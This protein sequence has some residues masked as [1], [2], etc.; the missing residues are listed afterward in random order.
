MQC[1]YPLTKHV[2]HVTGPPPS[3]GV[4]THTCLRQPITAVTTK[5]GQSHGT[6]LLPHHPRVITQAHKVST[7]LNPKI[8]QPP[9]QA[10]RYPR[11]HPKPH[12]SSPKH[13]IRPVV[14]QAPGALQ[15]RAPHTNTP[16][17]LQPGHRLRRPGWAMSRPPC[18]V[19]QGTRRRWPA[20][21]RARAVPS[22]SSSSRTPAPVSPRGRLRPPIIPLLV[23]RLPGVLLLPWAASECAAGAQAPLL[24]WAAVRD[25]CL[26]LH[27]VNNLRVVCSST[28]NT[29]HHPVTQPELIDAPIA[30]W[31]HP[32]HSPGAS[33]HVPRNH[34]VGTQPQEL[35]STPCAAG[36]I[37]ADPTCRSSDGCP[38]RARCCRCCGPYRN[39]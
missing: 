21:G 31:A 34:I 14:P 24:P 4:P 6:P 1:I 2:P 36:R 25:R 29:G 27:E 16:S 17:M 28:R 33:L 39:P 5:W 26:T 38:C 35:R 3:E 37:A 7:S 23:W 13:Y 32:I 9:E 20:R 22:C 18:T 15:R 30:P 10:T 12:L 8:A 11:P 19:L